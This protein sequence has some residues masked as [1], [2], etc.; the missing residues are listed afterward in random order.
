M[1][2][3]A[4]GSA[5]LVAMLALAKSAKAAAPMAISLS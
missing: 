2:T 5:T 4:L 1:K 3:R